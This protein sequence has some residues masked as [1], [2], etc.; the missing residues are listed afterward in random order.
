MLIKIY[1]YAVDSSKLN[2]W[3]IPR[4]RSADNH[5]WY[6]GKSYGQGSQYLYRQ[7]GDHHA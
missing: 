7:G 3:N 4:P 2:M 6:K 5:P 1:A